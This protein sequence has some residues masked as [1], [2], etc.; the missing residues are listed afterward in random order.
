MN[1]Y[2]E[3]CH[4]DLDKKALTYFGRPITY[5]AF[6]SKIQE[7]ET[8]LRAIGVT[9]YSI[10]TMALPTTPESIACFYALNKIG[11]TASYV[12]V[13]YK[14]NKIKQIMQQTNSRILFAMSFM[15]KELVQDSSLLEQCDYIIIQRGTESLYKP[16]RF[17]YQFADIFNGRMMIEKSHSN[18]YSYSDFVS[19]KC[20][21]VGTKHEES[22]LCN[23]IIFHT[24]GTTGQPKSVVISIDA[25]R[26]SIEMAPQ[27]LGTLLPSDTMLSIMPIF[28]SYGFITQ[29]HLPLTIGCD[30]IIIP[31][32]RQGEIFHHIHRYRPNYICGVASHW[33][34]FEKI[35]FRKHEIDNLKRILFTGERSNYAFLQSF[36]NW[37]R[38]NNSQ[39]SVVT[40]YGMTE[41]GPVSC[42]HPEIDSPFK[43]ENG[44]AGFTMD[45]VEVKEIDDEICVHSPCMMTEYLN[46]EAATRYLIRLHD[47]NK[48]WIHTGDTGK[49]NNDGSITILGRTKR[50]IVCQDGSKIFLSEIEDAL[51]LHPDVLDC[52]V[53]AAIADKETKNEDM[54]AFVVMNGD[55]KSNKGLQRWLKQQL[56]E[57]QIPRKIYLLDKLPHTITGKV[58]YEALLNINRLKDQ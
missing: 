38:N 58:N 36:T 11:A 45:T 55:N 48:L 3:L 20:K 28:T 26:K 19:N 42:T 23:S 4:N 15:L 34:N 10:I 8:A 32:L 17:F 54:I 57:H 1:L 41:S 40:A 2:D 52:A 25:I 13:R 43:R 35:C 49:I 31:Y 16:V 18:I 24:S 21:K 51:L 39:A 56:P 47:D 30:I 29:I 46:D 44:F 27:M 5:G 53:I 22:K 12:D 37:L 33:N 7:A 9:E 50:M 6:F 14:A